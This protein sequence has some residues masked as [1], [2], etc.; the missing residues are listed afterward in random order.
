MTD[1]DETRTQAFWWESRVAEIDRRTLY[2]RQMARVCGCSNCGD[3][4]RLKELKGLIAT[5]NGL[6]EAFEDELMDGAG[7]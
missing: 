6:I 5:C 7:H 4:A 2:E 3:G 1:L